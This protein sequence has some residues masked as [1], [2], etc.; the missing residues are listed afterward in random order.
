MNDLPWTTQDTLSSS[1]ESAPSE[2]HSSSNI[3]TA[4]DYVEDYDDID[5]NDNVISTASTTSSPTPARRYN[6]QELRNLATLLDRLG[7]TLTDAAP[8]VASL[9]ANL[10][11]EEEEEEEAE[12]DDDGEQSSEL[13]D[14][15]AL[16][17]GARGPMYSLFSSERRRRQQLTRTASAETSTS[18]TVD[19][20]HVDY[21]GGMVN[22]TRGEV[23]SGPRSRSSNDDVAGFLGAYL[24]AASIGNV[25]TSDGDDGMI[26]G[27]SQLLR[28]AGAT[29]GG[30]GIDIHIH[31]I[32]TTPGGGLGVATTG[33]GG[34]GGASP[35][36]G[37][38][39]T[40]NLFSSTR[41]PTTNSILRSSRNNS[42]N[43]V[44][45][46]QAFDDDDD[47]GLFSELYS[48]TPAPV[49]PN[50]SPGPGEQ[51]RR[52]SV[53][54]MDLLQSEESVSE[55]VSEYF[56]R[57]N[58]FNSPLR[59]GEG[60]DPTSDILAQINQHSSLEHGNVTGVSSTRRRLRRSIRQ[61]TDEGNR[62]DNANASS[63]RRSPWGR[64]FGRRRSSRG[65]DDF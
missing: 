37:N 8:H 60:T 12:E 29:G 32:V 62:T 25:S 55:S 16:D 7:R 30:G 50:G 20:D 43:V 18:P 40:R 34:G 13:D 11:Q 10:P 46:R 54:D 61:P 44:N 28:G 49:N 21:I 57:L 42:S 26:S 6:Q 1:S 36:T 59:R 4:F 22:S 64:L 38:G 5:G 63:N 27:L 56:S 47:N 2:G 31:A 15:L 9:A 33:G 52:S 19:P 48:E 17:E 35:G 41:R 53:S 3:L 23:R 51:P 39:V 45:H 24:A 14:I 58:T 65:P